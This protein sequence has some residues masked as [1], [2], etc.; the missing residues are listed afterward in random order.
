MTGPA[1]PA[2]WRVLGAALG[3][4]LAAC[5]SAAAPEAARAVPRVVLE[6]PEG[7]RHVVTVELARTPREQEQ[8]M[9]H[10]RELAEDAGM[11]FVFPASERR[12][13]WMR[14]TLIPLDMIFIDDG[15]RVAGIVENAEPLT[16]TPRDPG[17]PARY[18]LEVRGGWAARHG[19]RP[20]A[21]VRFE[22]VPLG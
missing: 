4:A 1:R 2:A 7:A 16:L 20:G 3:L 21:R 5:A 13:F 10:R 14:N 9:M 19:V 22:N 8:G 6:T 17:V 11:L 12:A 18:V 15:G